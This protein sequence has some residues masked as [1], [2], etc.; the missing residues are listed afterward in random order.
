MDSIN[1]RIK[2]LRTELGMNQ[3]D[4]GKELGI[5]QTYLSQI[6]KGDRDVTDKIFKLIC[7]VLWDGKHVNEK[8]LETG[9]GD[10]FVNLPKEAEI[11]NFLSDV[12]HL[13][14]DNFQKRL[15]LALAKLDSDGWQKLEDLIDAITNK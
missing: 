10:M 1:K 7:L 3:T 15:I 8:W 13:N 6:E 9:D 11:S 4:F 5:A 2:Q 14:D 12:Q